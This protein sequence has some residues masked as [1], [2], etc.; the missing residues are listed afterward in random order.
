MRDALRQESRP[1]P[2]GHRA[3]WRRWT[4]Y[5]SSLALAAG[6]TMA[7]T[8]PASAAPEDVSEGLG[9]FLGG[10]A[11]GLNLDAIVE[12]QGA[13]AENPSGTNPVSATPL[14]AELLNSVGVDLGGSLQ[15]LGP[16][17]ILQLGTVNQF[18]EAT[19]E[20]DAR[21]AAG[22]VSDQGAI[23]VGGSGEFPAKRGPQPDPAAH[24]DR[25]GEHPQR[26]EPEPR[27]CLLQR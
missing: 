10:D 27:S 18:G 3:P 20:G 22:A 4:A 25:G 1:R 17:G 11:A 2:P 19:D 5:A 14:S 7:G 6:L 13:Y 9:Q 23:S 24:R 15:L 21:A 26:A 8:V 16:N 12:L